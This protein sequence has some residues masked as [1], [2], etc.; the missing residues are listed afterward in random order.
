MKQNKQVQGKFL[1]TADLRNGISL[2][3]NYVYDLLV[4]ELELSLAP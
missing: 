4:H 3:K 1:P 2:G